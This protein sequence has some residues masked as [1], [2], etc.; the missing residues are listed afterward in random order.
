[1]DRHVNRKPIVALVSATCLLFGAWQLGQGAWLEAKARLAQLLLQQAWSQTLDGSR[2]VRPWPGADTW[3]LAR[4]QVKRLGVDQIV[5]ADA[6]GRSMAFGPGH[7]VGTGE[8]GGGGNSAISGHR[9]THFRF[10]QQ[11]QTG[12]QLQLTLRDG[13]MHGYQITGASIHHKDE[14]WLLGETKNEQLTL[15]TCYP[16]NAIVPGGPMRYVVQA[17]AVVF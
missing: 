16:F 13:V 8:L 2:Q 6:S 14:T 12:D 5:L 17:R 15:I 1:M 11:L 7:V 4:M 3:P 9:D 10:L